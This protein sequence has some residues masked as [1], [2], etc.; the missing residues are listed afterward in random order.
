[1]YA[2]IFLFLACEQRRSIVR[3]MIKHSKLFLSNF[4]KPFNSK[5]DKKTTGYDHPDTYRIKR[6]HSLSE[7][8]NIVPLLG[9][10]KKEYALVSLPEQEELTTARNL[11]I[12]SNFVSLM[13]QKEEEGKS[14]LLSAISLSL[15]SY[16]NLHCH[17]FAE[18]FYLNVMKGE[19]L[20]LTK[21][22]KVHLM[23]HV[24]ESEGSQKVLC[25]MILGSA[26]FYRIL[27]YLKQTTD[28]EVLRQCVQLKGLFFENDHSNNSD[29]NVI[30]CF[31]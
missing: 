14:N 11:M 22:E 17:G 16:E 7:C 6:P 5:D 31:V 18:N 28:M 4:P 2:S 8:L 21:K 20:G 26:A 19:L 1:M 12:I 9:L 24:L 15:I 25:T 13:E 23:I 10:V 30:Y 27:D 3:I 29:L